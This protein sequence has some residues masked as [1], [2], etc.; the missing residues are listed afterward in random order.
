M[1]G[2]YQLA[3]LTYENGRKQSFVEEGK[4]KK[5]M[6]TR[7][8]DL[9]NGEDS[10]VVVDP[11]GFLLLGGKR[12]EGS[13]GEVEVCP[14]ERKRSRVSLRREGERR[15]EGGKKKEV[16]LTSRDFLKLILGEVLGAIYDGER[17]SSVG[18]AEVEGEYVDEVVRERREGG[19]RAH[20]G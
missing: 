9:W 2:I 7:R 10:N 3:D 1:E 14:A 18:F 16:E 15:R 4:S 19:P 20:R 13:L 12:G 11:A 17:V 6:L 5:S 8:T